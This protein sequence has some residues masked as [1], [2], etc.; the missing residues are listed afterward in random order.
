[1]C[2]VLN[3][4]FDKDI[5]RY[6]DI[7][8]AYKDVNNGNKLAVPVSKDWAVSSSPFHSDPLL[9]NGLIGMYIGVMTKEDRV[10]IPES[11]S[12]LYESISEISD[13]LKVRT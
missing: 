12:F 9:Y 6:K 10:H 11:A 7:T 1:M 8:E 2:S 4:I 3:F 5:N 13:K